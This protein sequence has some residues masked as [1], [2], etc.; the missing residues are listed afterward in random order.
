MGLSREEFTEFYNITGID[1][2]GRIE[3]IDNAFQFFEQK[4]SFVVAFAKSIPGFKSLKLDD[5]ANLLKGNII[6][7]G[8]ISE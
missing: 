5:Q 8:Q 3:R 2:D 7:R 6:I 4:I 1:L